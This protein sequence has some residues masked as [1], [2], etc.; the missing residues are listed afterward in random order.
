M[1]G[2][3]EKERSAILFA[4]RMFY[5]LLLAASVYGYLRERLAFQG[6][7]LLQFFVL[8]LSLAL[9][10]AVDC[11]R[12]RVPFYL[13]CAVLGAGALNGFLRE[14]AETLAGEKQTLFQKLFGGAQLQELCSMVFLAILAYL[15]WLLAES[16]R[17]VR[18][19]LTVLIILGLAAA[20]VFRR[21]VPHWSVA[22]V[23]LYLAST[24]TEEIQGS[25]KK[26][27]QGGNRLYFLW[28]APFLALYFV[29]AGLAPY[30]DT[31]YD[32]HFVKVIYQRAEKEFTKLTQNLFWG[33]NEDFGLSTSGFS[34]D[35]G[36]F[37]NM[38]KKDRQVIC[39]KGWPAYGEGV[40]LTGKIF[41]VFD[42]R[43]WSFEGHST[44]ADSWLDTLETRYA[45][46]RYGIGQQ[47][48]YV[49]NTELEIEFRYFHTKYLF[50]P[51]KTVWVNGLK[52]AKDYE[53]Q[54]G[55]FQF[56]KRRG[57]G[58]T[59]RLCYSQMNSEHSD[60]IGL[61]QALPLPE[62]EEIWS[63]V[64]GE[65]GRDY[66]LQTL[67]DYQSRMRSQYLIKPE[68]GERVR[69]WL[70]GVLENADTEYEKLRRLEKALSE[71]DYNLRPGE[72]PPEVCSENT[73]LEYFLLE[74]REG[75]C[76]YFA[77]AFVLL[78]RAEGIPAR[79][80]QGFCIPGKASNGWSEKETTVTSDMAH[81]WPEVYLEGFG[82][83]AFEPTPG[84][85]QYRSVSW[86]TSGDRE[87]EKEEQRLQE[88][89]MSR[90]KEPA[91][92]WTEQREA[93]ETP[94]EE[95]GLSVRERIRLAAFLF[96]VLAAIFALF[97]AADA[98]WEQM[99]RRR[100]SPMENFRLEFLR[101]LQI[102]DMLGYGKE[103]TET[104]SELAAKLSEDGEGL[105]D[106]GSPEFIRTCE[107]VLYGARTADEEAA[108]EIHAAGR[109][110]LRELKRRKGRS[111]PLWRIWL[112][113][114][115]AR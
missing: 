59:Y 73:F 52:E 6:N 30:R 55:V 78:A 82:W 9:L 94:K 48:D 31:P 13:V 63:L 10:A 64:V 107:E 7:I 68:I 108:E 72:L 29:L 92:E 89:S 44:E 40:Y 98:L 104:L 49:R 27:R 12:G 39:L 105:W 77:T 93:E 50:A 85:G 83:T 106:G 75:Y 114:T 28:L 34:D 24:V 16:F 58:T 61:L 113:L 100:R 33:R 19:A 46:Q 2:T 69:T 20:M 101:N 71:Y 32:W 87:K 36:F 96:G 23:L 54:A 70:D 90:E 112:Y 86:K 99:S 41:D 8:S 57:Y 115:R 5:A 88:E 1:A 15:L 51:L 26:V 60:F 43:N 91:Q 62:S 47:L 65:S 18:L 11:G 102:L 95:E 4:Y 37:G 67:K 74:S 14:P 81:A 66:T 25:W 35:S 3:Q 97:L 22:A 17:Q 79:Y 76:S 56:R 45:V 21:Q 53:A 103:E 110:L 111:Y 84:F 42:G 38:R 80:V 109:Y